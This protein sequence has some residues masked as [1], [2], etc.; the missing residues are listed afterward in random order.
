MVVSL[1]ANAAS[2]E[3]GLSTTLSFTFSGQ[4]PPAHAF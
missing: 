1:P 2:S 3:Q 4:Q